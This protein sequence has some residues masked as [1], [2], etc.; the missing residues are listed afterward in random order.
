MTEDQQFKDDSGKRALATI[1]FTDVVNFSERMNKDEDGTLKLLSKDLAWMTDLTEKRQGRVI[2]S[3]GD[4]LMIYFDSAVEAVAWSLDIQNIKSRQLSENQ[5]GEHL[6][7]RIGIH[8][9][10]VFFKDSDLMGDGVNIA[11]RLEGIAQPGGIC[12]SQIVYDTVKNK[13]PLNA[14]FLG[15]QKLKN[16]DEKIPVH[17]IEVGDDKVALPETETVKAMQMNPKRK[18][19]GK[20]LYIGAVVL[21]IVLASLFYYV[22]INRI[23]QVP[24]IV[25][26]QSK[27]IAVLPF[28]DMSPEKDQEYFSDG[29]SE[30]IINVLAKIDTLQVASRT[31]SFQ[32]K[33]KNADIPTIGKQLNVSTVLEGSVRKS[34]RTI[35]V[36][37]QLINVADDL[38]LWSETYDREL[39]NIFAIQDEIA[40]AITQVLQ[41]KLMGDEDIPHIK[42]HT[43]NVDAYDHYLLGRYHWSKRT[44][45]GIMT[46]IEHYKQAI[47]LDPDYALAYSGL[48]DAYLVLPSYASAVKRYDIRAHAKE[49][50][51][52]ALAIDPNLAEA[53]TSLGYTR[54]VFHFDYAGAEKEYRYSIELNS[55]YAPAHYRYSHL[56]MCTGRLREA[57]AKGKK[58][59]ELEPFSILYNNHLG[60]LYNYA[61]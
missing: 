8:I 14:K 56:L 44:E 2:K 57:L 7:H 1:V 46:A 10:D 43:E 11:S 54:E 25:E 55:K 4:G 51:K 45:K 34:G 29:I 61:R 5:P 47:T 6:Q 53:Y 18:S 32:F 12:I 52:M 40:L 37:A 24:V 60:T 19:P 20:T 27:S 16:L 33:G 38:H 28:Q 31:S 39:K 30:E 48:A 42:P 15:L 23:E 21:V 9:G 26:S 17:H 59:L 36:T 50:V 49:A 13:L 41:V 3:T 35:R 58:A 22:E